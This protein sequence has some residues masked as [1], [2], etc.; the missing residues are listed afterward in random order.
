MN[1]EEYKQ[2]LAEYIE[3]LFIQNP[4]N[5]HDKGFNDAIREIYNHVV[6]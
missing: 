5:E 2:Q 3:E 6:V 1:T 4:Q